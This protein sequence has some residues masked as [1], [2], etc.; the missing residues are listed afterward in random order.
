MDR[1]FK[2]DPTSDTKCD[3]LWYLTNSDHQLYLLS[4]DPGSRATTQQILYCR[5]N[6]FNKPLSATIMDTQTGPWTLLWHK[7][8]RENVACIRC[9]GNVFT[10]PLSSNDREMHIRTDGWELFMKHVAHVIPC[11]IKIGWSIQTLRGEHT[12]TAKWTHK[13]AY[14]F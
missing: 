8:R 5:G 4:H 13:P 2:F 11:F 7:D 9:R 10:E 14:I 12:Q 1:V 6:V 3:V